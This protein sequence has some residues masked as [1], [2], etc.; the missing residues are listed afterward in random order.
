MPWAAG[1]YTKGNNSTGGWTGDA[2]LGIG[3]EA[4]RHDTQDNDFATGINQCLNKDG[5]N[6]CTGDL[7]LGGFKPVNLAAGTAAAPA[8]CAG[9]DVNTGI[10]SA[11]AD[12][13]GIATNG[14]EKIRIDSSGNI[15]IN[16][17]SPAFAL[18]IYGASTTG[19]LRGFTNDAGGP[20]F[21][22]N[23]SRS[24]TVG[25][26]T[27]VTSGDGLG[28]IT[29]QGA[30]GSSYT[31]AA[32]ITGSVDGTPGASNDMPG[33][34][35]FSTTADG[36]G[37]PTERMRI[38]S[39]GN[40]GIGVAGFGNIR[41]SIRGASATSSNFA[42]F[43]DNSSAS[44][45]FA[46]R[47][48]GQFRT[49]IAASSP[50]NN[51][52]GSSPNVVVGSDGTLSRQSSSLKYKE[53]VEDMT[54]GLDNVMELRPVTYKGKAEADGK[55]RFGGLVAEEVHDA[56]LHEFVVYNAD[57]EP[58][59]LHYGNMV[60]L[61]FKAIQELNAKVEALEARVAELEA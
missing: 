23:K 15:G 7:N 9:G 33:R 38:A 48:D 2:S 40:V 5:S 14:T 44:E 17:T 11:A 43:C 60:A 28:T 35:V 54:Y 25:T 27:I 49:G 30:N 4:G 42:F 34:L 18:D 13:I 52:T 24:A 55:K 57:N 58:D 10:F 12:Q 19:I 31:S 36:S 20:G 59:A 26:N 53:Q 6:S 56:G 32:S 3:I 1:T 29:W 22:F 41:T 8:I 21:V 45:L 51:T 61:A 50:Y 39:D 16:T 37:T 47:N 46:I